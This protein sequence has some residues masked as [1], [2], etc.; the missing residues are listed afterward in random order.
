MSSISPMELRR[1]THC[2]RFHRVPL[3][4]YPMWPTPRSGLPTVPEADFEFQSRR[5]SSRA[6]REDARLLMTTSFSMNWLGSARARAVS[7]CARQWPA[8]VF[9]FAIGFVVHV[10]ALSGQFLWDDSYLA[11]ES[12]FIKSPLLAVEAFRHHLFPCSSS[13]HY[14]PVQNLSYML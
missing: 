9:L 2:P 6:K 3:T 14:R 4:P 12:P 5:A 11:R 10:P 8:Y 1:W 7:F 13:G